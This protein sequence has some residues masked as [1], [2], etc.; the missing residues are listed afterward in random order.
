MRQTKKGV[1][2]YKAGCYVC[3][4]GQ[5]QWI[6]NNAVAIAA[7]HHDLTGHPTWCEYITTIKYGTQPSPKEPEN[8]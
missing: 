1:T 3:H 7:R 4:K 2:E 8:A 5:V 6:G